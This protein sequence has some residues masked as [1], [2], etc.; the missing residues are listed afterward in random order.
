MTAGRRLVWACIAAL[1]VPV[2]AGA[3]TI[4][5]ANWPT[6]RPPRPLAA[7]PVAFPPYQLKTLANGL[8]V[9]LVPWHEQPSV[10]MRLI[11][12]AGAAQDPAGKPGVASLVASLLDQGTAMKTSEGIANLVESA[13]GVLGVGAG[14]ELSFVNA[15]VIKDKFDV[16][17]GLMAELVQQPAFDQKE[18]DRLKQQALSGMQV[19]YEDPDFVAG[20]VIDRLMY[21]F[22]PYGQPPG[23]TLD[24]LAKLTRNDLLAFHRTWFAPN[25]AILAIVGDLAADDM[26]AGV[27]KAF[28][29]WP[30]R[31]VPAQAQAEPPPPTWRVVVVDKPGAVQTEIRAGQLTLPRTSPDWLTLELLIRI[32]GGEGANRLFGVLRTDR[33]LTYGASADL[34]TFKFSGGYV[35][36]TN[37]RTETTGEALRLL[38]DEITRLT[39][40][41]VGE[42]ELGG[43][44]DFFGGN[45][46]LT[47]ETP[48]AIAIQVLNQLFYGLDLKSLEQMRDQVSMVTADQLQAVARKWLKSDRLSIVL[49]GDASKFVGQL[50]S[51]GFN[52]FERIP[53][54][55]LDLTT[56][57]L[58]RGS[59]APV[60][61][62]GSSASATDGTAAALL[63]KV[64]AAKGGL[65]VLR[66]VR[67]I[68]AEADVT[69]AEPGQTPLPMKTR[70]LIAYPDR[71]RVE[72]RAAG[73]SLVQVFSGQDAWVET[74]AGPMDADAETRADYAASFARDLV[75]LLLAATDGKVPV[76]ALD[77]TMVAGVAYPTLQFRTV[78]GGPVVMLVDPRTSD[79]RSLRYPTDPSPNAPQAH[80]WF[81]DYR[82]VSGLRVAFRATVDREG[83][84]IRRAITRL[85]INGTL[86]ST[87]FVRK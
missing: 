76:V 31:A 67:T 64:I 49:V 63:T 28:G 5:A 37:T 33:G 13:G 14:N 87:A 8:Q 4:G 86:P 57:S 78:A 30:T 77:D 24:S 11:I 7:R 55:Q 47:I 19:S 22:H 25:N 84:T 80:E 54:D 72:A 62:A 48:S 73:D 2:A 12:K 85:S 10:S 29:S 16:V 52:E 83:A 53:I 20:V 21:G 58:R 36:A 70:N 66:G 65:E 45:F 59:S 3:Q 46:P 35:A 56:T 9:V 74:A 34:Q 82:P 1:A 39:R 44:Q 71:F 61:A 50:R 51:L 60:A 68:D 43:V 69:I 32:L 23:G 18:I 27:E 75:A 41:R 6:E 38:V 17:L 42:R 26:L 15:G 40:E 79:V 81:D